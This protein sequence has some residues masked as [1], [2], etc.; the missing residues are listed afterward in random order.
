MTTIYCFSLYMGYDPGSCD[1]PDVADYT[2]TQVL[3]RWKVPKD[4]GYSPILAY[5]LQAKQL[6]KHAESIDTFDTL[7]EKL[8]STGSAQRFV[9]ERIFIILHHPSVTLLVENKTT[10]LAVDNT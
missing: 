7:R 9:R 2:D 1:L 6:S 8:H 4:T 5:G 3:L 10:D